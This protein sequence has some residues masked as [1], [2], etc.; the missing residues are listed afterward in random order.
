MKNM[1]ILEV[2]KIFHKSV[3]TVN[4]INV[5]KQKLDF[6]NQMFLESID[7]QEDLIQYFEN[8]RNLKIK[9]K[10]SENAYKKVIVYMAKLLKDKA[11]FSEVCKN[12]LAKH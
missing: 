5:D 7:N 6:A 9:G 4:E 12:I 1:V 11:D 2:I 10:I 8:I 3:I